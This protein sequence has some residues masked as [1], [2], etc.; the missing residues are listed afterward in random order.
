MKFTLAFVL[1]NRIDVVWAVH[2][3]ES[4]M[5]VLS[6]AQNWLCLRCMWYSI[7]WVCAICGTVSTESAL[8][9]IQSRPCMRCLRQRFNHA[10]AV[11]VLIRINP[12]WVLRHSFKSDY[13]VY[14]AFTGGGIKPLTQLTELNYF[15]LF[16]GPHRCVHSVAVQQSIFD[17]IQYRQLCIDC[18]SS[19]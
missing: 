3:T 4:I 18:E 8:S 10:C 13:G 17:S 2:G 6:M 19:E 1:Y 5:P 15:C 9:E 16:I 7:D 12:R 11:M 14:M